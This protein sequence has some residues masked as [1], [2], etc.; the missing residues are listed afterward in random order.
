MM[1]E[2]E[3]PIQLPRMLMGHYD[4]QTTLSYG[5]KTLPQVGR[6]ANVQ[7]VEMLRRRA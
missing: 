2:L 1:S 6:S 3:I 7:V 5:G 4:I